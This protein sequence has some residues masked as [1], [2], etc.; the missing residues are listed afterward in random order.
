MPQWNY[1]NLV[2]GGA[3]SDGLTVEQGIAFYESNVNGNMP[4]TRKNVRRLTTT[5]PWGAY[6]RSFGGSEPGFRMNFAG[7][8]TAGVAPNSAPYEWYSG[9]GNMLQLTLERD[10]VGVP[11]AS[12]LDFMTWYDIEEDWDY[13]YVEASADGGATWTKLPQITTLRAGVSNLFG[14]TAWDGAGGLTGSSAGWKPAQFDLAG[15][16]GNVKIRFRYAT[17]EASNGQGWY[18]DDLQVGGVLNDPVAS[19]AGWTTNG[20]LFTT[21]MQDNDWTADLYVPY[22]KAGKTWY[23]VTPFVGVAGSGASG[24]TWVNTQYLKSGK[25]YGIVSNRPRNGT[26]AAAGRLTILKGK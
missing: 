20:W 21:G 12:K 23:T 10:L 6:Y 9:L 16:T 14:S 3:D 13:G 17:D 11:A 5:E 22:A 26:F 2:L 19:A 25:T 4:P 7:V 18:I 8:P 1:R 15:F 24:S